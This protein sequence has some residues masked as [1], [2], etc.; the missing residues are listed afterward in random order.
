M[1]KVSRV[2]H[3]VRGRARRA[4]VHRFPMSL[5]LHRRF[6]QRLRFVSRDLRNR[7]QYGTDAPRHSEL[8]FVDP[9]RCTRTMDWH[10]CAERNMFQ[11]A[12]VVSDRFWE[13]G[14][15]LLSD[16][17]KMEGL[18]EHWT[19]GLP[20]ED[21]QTYQGLLKQII[22]RPGKEGCWSEQDVANRFKRLDAIFEETRHLGRFKTRR[23]LDPN[24]LR[25]L[26]SVRFFI[27]EGGEPI[28]AGSGLHRL[29]MA[30]VLQ[31]PLPAVAVL[32]YEDALD[33]YNRMRV[34]PD[35]SVAI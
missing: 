15:L 8:I 32:I 5:P 10:Y 34:P 6:K 1:L 23:E 4:V 7:I 18:I 20:W 30:M 21:T 16:F 25:E 22:K 14:T 24:N 28:F 13:G 9:R 17:W 11:D 27:A 33:D 35:M 19:N 3:S 2:L 12:K 26:D 29:S 31:I